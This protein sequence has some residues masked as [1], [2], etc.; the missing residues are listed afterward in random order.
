ML[1]RGLG[2]CASYA[3]NVRYGPSSVTESVPV[4]IVDTYE[5]LSRLKWTW[6]LCRRTEFSLC[7]RLLAIGYQQWEPSFLVM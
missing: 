5:L 3:V 7:A 4:D 6:L 2:W 1:A